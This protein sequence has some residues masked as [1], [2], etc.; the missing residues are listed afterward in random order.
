[1]PP[2]GR[3]L[4][5]CERSKTPERIILKSGTDIHDPLRMTLHDSVES[6]TFAAATPTDLHN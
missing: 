1:M 2:A 3:A 6:L 5:L 4:F